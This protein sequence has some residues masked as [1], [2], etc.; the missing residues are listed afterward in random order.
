[1]KQVLLEITEELLQAIDASKGSETRNAYI[2]RCLWNASTIKKAAKELGIEK[3]V[4]PRWGKT[5][6]VEK[7]AAKQKSN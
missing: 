3:P 7:S 6:K 5:K 1:M 4:R 2:E